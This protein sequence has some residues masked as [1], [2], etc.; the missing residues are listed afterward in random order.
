MPKKY[1]HIPP[2]EGWEENSYYVVEVSRG[3]GNPIFLGI[4]YTGFLSKTG[5][6]QGYSGIFNPTTETKFSRLSYFQY[7]KAIRKIDV[8][9]PNECK[10]ITQVNTFEMKIHERTIK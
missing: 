4:L 5:E 9:I 7:I 2:L 10:D 8:S 6:P 3:K 1:Y